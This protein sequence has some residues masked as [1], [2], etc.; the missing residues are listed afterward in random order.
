MPARTRR[1]Q[2]MPRPTQKGHKTTNVLVKKATSEIQKKPRS[3]GQVTRRDLEAA[4]ALRDVHT[5]VKVNKPSTL[6][7]IVWKPLVKQART[8]NLQSGSIMDIFRIIDSVHDIYDRGVQQKIKAMLPPPILTNSEKHELKSIQIN[9]NSLKGKRGVKNIKADLLKRK[10]ELE[11]KLPKKVSENKKPPYPENE[12]VEDI[13]NFRQVYNGVYRSIND[14]HF[15]ALTFKSWVQQ[16]LEMI[17][18][19]VPSLSDM[20]NAWKTKFLLLAQQRNMTLFDQ[21]LTC[22]ALPHVNITNS[23]MSRTLTG[24]IIKNY[25]LLLATDALK[26]SDTLSNTQV[27]EVTVKTGLD[28]ILND[29]SL[30]DNYIVN[31]AQVVDPA[32]NIRTEKMYR[33]AFV[34][35]TRLSNVQQHLGINSTLFSTFY[36][37]NDTNEQFTCKFKIIIEIINNHGNQVIAELENYINRNLKTDFLSNDKTTPLEFFTHVRVYVF[38]VFETRENKK[39]STQL[40][41]N[42]LC[43][44]TKSFTKRYPAYAWQEIPNQRSFFKVQK[45]LT[46]FSVEEVIKFMQM[47]TPKS[48]DPRVIKWII[49]HY[50]DWKRMGDSF[51][52]TH[53]LKLSQL[54]NMKFVG[55]HNLQGYHP[56][57]FV[58]I[59]ILAIV[60]AIMFNVNFVYQMNGN[61]FIIGNNQHGTPM[62][63]YIVQ[64][65]NSCK[66]IV[67]QRKENKKK[68][69]NLETGTTTLMVMANNTGNNTGNNNDYEMSFDE[70]L[71]DPSFTYDNLKENDL[72]RML[73]QCRHRYLQLKYGRRG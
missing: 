54:N 69:N 38:P 66:R 64:V 29:K 44:Q 22:K 27:N 13:F 43:I 70:T 45:D 53:M 37:L 1:V 33:F 21:K 52:I 61:A 63:K 4:K 24:N 71:K 10:T 28:Q 23:K 68:Q 12:F 5:P 58:S 40:S 19:G 20:K 62:S 26:T 55:K 56:Y 17:S 8:D 16:Y 73:N 6:G 31:M 50:L 25:K 3:M 30:E 34:P 59:D 42:G 65:M 41:V 9:L 48:R 49:R 36:E 51:Q 60:Q 35:L 32:T 18:M 2:N 57:H 47:D 67:N 14:K 7:N 15:K 11:K 39:M 72:L 46:G